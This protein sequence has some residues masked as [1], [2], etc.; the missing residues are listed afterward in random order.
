MYEEADIIIYGGTSAGIMAAVQAKILGKSV[1]LVSPDTHLGGLSV[2]GLG[3]SDTG[4]TKTIGGLAREF[5]HR[6][7]LEYK[8][9]ETWKWEKQRDYANQGQGHSAMDDETGT[10]WCF[11]PHLAEKVFLDLLAEYHVEVRRGEYLN[12]SRGL[13][14]D[15]NIIRS[16]ASLGGT[17]YRGKQFIDA[18]YEGDL[19]AA[20]GVSYVLGRE[21]NKEYGER[22]NGVQTGTF[23]HNHYFKQKIDP[24][25]I[26]GDS[27]GGLLPLVD[28][29]APGEYGAADRRLQAYC[30]RLCMTDHSGNMTPITKPEAYDPGV[31][32]LLGRLARAGWDEYFDKYDRI[33]NRKT[34][35]NNHGPVNFD[36]IGMSDDYPEASYRR[37]LSIMAEHEQYQR[38]L[39]YFLR[40]D[41]R[42]PLDIR[43]KNNSW[44]LAADEFTGNGNWPYQLYIREARRMRGEHVITE[45]EILGVSPVEESAGL[46]SYHLDSHNT[47]RYVDAAG[48]VQNEGDIGIPAPHPYAIHRM[49]LFPKKRECANLVV[50]VC[51]SASH[52]TYGSI[53]MEPVFMILGQSAAAAAVLA[54]DENRPPQDL[55]YGALKEILIKTG[56]ILFSPAG[57]DS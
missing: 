45:R 47:H 35:T 27:A 39:L 51:L 34:D 15:G 32:E 9:P 48:F 8:K 23:H 31:Y 22:W 17:V 16:M 3:F 19:M 25:V 5:Y 40:S 4:N 6:L 18:S 26:E 41:P 20:A 56:Q 7:W 57:E 36:Y 46:G 52:S 44:G 49:A 29:E 11:E 1:I 12:R 28:G 10:A 30:F 42:I 55:P 43:D 24:Y 13:V 14:K 54:A 2:N 38:G 50:P 21:A 33:P 37:R 53:R